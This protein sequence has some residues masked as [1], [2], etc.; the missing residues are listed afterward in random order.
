MNLVSQRIKTASKAA[1]IHL[2]LSMLVALSAAILVFGIWFPY[3]YR[4]FSGGR[5]LFLLVMAVDVVCGPL[6]TFVLYNPAKP[7]SELVRDLGLVSLIQMA[8]LVYGV[9]TVWQVRPLFLV[10]EIDRFK[11]VTVSEL[12][13]T[14]LAA[15]QRSMKPALFT[16][17]L[18]VAIRAP[19]DQ[20]EREKVMFES[21]E[22]GRDYAERPEFYLP[23]EGE[24]ALKSLKRAKP[25]TLFLQKYTEQSSAAKNLAEE[26]KKAVA[27]LFY[28]P[29]MA[30]Q[31]WVAVLDKQ[32]QI[33]GFLKGDGF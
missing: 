23:Y 32:G 26:K 33:Q 30:L 28:L 20:A 3:P 9:H 18:V 19:K 7:K 24:N 15:L 2:G 29:V 5:E 27:E 6:L 8:A 16:G 21:L 31:D 1:T 25:L 10:Q 14:A 22:G 4:E 17:P 12:D 11:V 13:P